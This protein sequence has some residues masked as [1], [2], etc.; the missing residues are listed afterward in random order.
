MVAPAVLLSADKSFFL[1]A[2]KTASRSFL[3]STARTRSN[4]DPSLVYF[5]VGPQWDSLRA[6]QRFNERLRRMALR[7]L[8]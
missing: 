5:A 3:L 6:D 8:Q 4:S 2:D 7:F 1:S